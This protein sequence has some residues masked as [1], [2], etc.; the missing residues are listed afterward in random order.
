MSHDLGWN[1][2]E[3]LQAALA[4]AAGWRG[5]H[6]AV[7]GAPSVLRSRDSTNKLNLA[8]IGVNNRGAANLAAVAQENIVAL[9]DVDEEWS[10][11]Q[12]SRFPQ[13]AFFT[14]YRRMFDQLH[15][16]IDAV[17]ISTPDHQH[18]LPA[19]IALSLG[20]HVYC[21]KPLTLTVQEA[22]HLR[23][24][25][26]VKKCITQMGT[27]IHA[28]EN[29]RRVVEWVRSGVLGPVQ[30]VLVWNSSKPV[31]GR[32]VNKPPVTKV[33]RDLWLGPNENAFFEAEMLPSGWKFPWPHFHWRWWWEYGGG[34]LADLGCHYLD[35]PFWALDLSA[36][37]RI[38][39]CGRK[40]YSGDNNVPDVMQVDY[41]FPPRGQQPAVHLTWYHGVPGP[42]LEGKET[43]KGYPAG[44]LFVGEKGRLV[45]DYSK[46]QLLPDELARSATPPPRSIPPSVG[47]HREW[48][49]AIRQ[50]SLPSCH[51]G[52]AGPLTET[53]LL[54]NVAYRAG[55]AISWNHEKGTTG[56]STADG[57]L[58]R[59]YR[60][61]WE[62]P[63]VG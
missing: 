48:C 31:G 29:Y 32:R 43:Y 23:Q 54:G 1:R 47:H 8:I 46:H 15:Q 21:E 51:F 22:R 57:L 4:L 10:A 56:D 11:Q 2:R 49:D 3:V 40:T 45:A 34:T 55:K 58:G 14:D 19:A 33:N 36:P 9:C 5:F 17:I 28:G 39:A 24:L 18:A 61:G 7:Q 25:A 60:K 13:A 26:A 6:N 52:Y 12:R 53:V 50:G 41:Y 27:Q 35:L 59:N 63:K 42:D 44:V 37:T 62:L 16:K 38:E 20:K 30:R